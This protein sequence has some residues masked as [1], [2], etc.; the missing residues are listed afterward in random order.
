M[1]KRKLLEEWTTPDNLLRVQGWAR[2][3]LTMEQIAYN[4]GITKNTL[5]RWQDRDSDFLNALKVNRDAA[6]REVENAL[7][8]NAIGFHY[9]EQQVTDTGDVV[10]VEKYSKPNTT[11]QIFWLKNRKP[12]QWR[13]KQN[14]EH[15]GSINQSID[16]SNV[17]DKDL[18]KLANMSDK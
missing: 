15:D 13:D 10:D 1:A 8:K 5:Y 16:L 11:A 3:G 6:D 18:E 17:S 4:I 9:T 2:D 14:I 12:A 7:F